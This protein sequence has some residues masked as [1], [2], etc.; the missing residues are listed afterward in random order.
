M[1][2]ILAPTDFSACAADALDYALQLA[3]AFGEAEVTLL[4]TYEVQSNAGMFVSVRDFMRR[5]A[6][7]Q[8][9]ELINKHRPAVKPGVSLHARVINGDTVPMITELA[10]AEGFSLIVMGTKGASGLREV[11]I[12]STANAVLTRS[13]VPVLAVP[14]GYHFAPIR[15]IAFAVDGEGISGA[16]VTLPL[17]QI[18]RAFEAP[19]L[20]Y[21]QAE[22]RQDDGIDPSVDIFLDGVPHSFHYELD[23]GPV[24]D[25]INAFVVDTGAE[26][27]AMLRRKRGFLETV[28]HTSA[29]TKEVFQSTVPLLVLQE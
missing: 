26:L 25:S 17:R 18:A 19:V 1:M 28:F 7:E 3:A 10:R 24:L 8:L 4:H 6:E 29:T 27:L 14:E 23:E 22:S 15:Q 5:D 16:E 13:A 2:K 12:G 20:V 21:H 11:F 9:K